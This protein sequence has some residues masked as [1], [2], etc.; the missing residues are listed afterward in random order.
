MDDVE[1][2]QQTLAEQISKLP[3]EL[4][5]FLN[6]DF[7]KGT[8]RVIA[9]HRLVD[10]KAATFYEETMFVVIGLVT[11]QDYIQN[12]IEEGGFTQDEVDVLIP[13]VYEFIFKPMTLLAKKPVIAP[14]P[15]PAV[16]EVP[17]TP[18]TP[19]ATVLPVEPMIHNDII[20]PST[21]P[22]PVPPVT[23]KPQTPP[24]VPP[25]IQKELSQPTPQASDAFKKRYAVD[26]YREP[27]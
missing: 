2:A 20:P 12:L 15:E 16:P 8:D 5:S 26:P 6:T 22:L 27:L 18:V 10:P 21:D 11:P 25:P 4:R 23:P 24:V 19:P 9:K 13:D 1:V 3:P 7:E 17:P 14:P